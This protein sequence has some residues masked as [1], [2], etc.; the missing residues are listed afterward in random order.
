MRGRKTPGSHPGRRLSFAVWAGS[1]WPLLR[2]E[3]ALDGGTP[4][5]GAGAAADAWGESVLV[6]AGGFFLIGA[7]GVVRVGVGCLKL[8][9]VDEDAIQIH[10]VVL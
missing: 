8:L 3:P 2:V 10:Y 5:T 4:R 6:L 7:R 1:D 9:A